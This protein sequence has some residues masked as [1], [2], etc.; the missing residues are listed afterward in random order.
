MQKF[1]KKGLKKKSEN[2]SEW[3]TDVILKAE[4]ADYAPVKGCMVIRPYGYS[5]W[6]GIRKFLDMYIKERGVKNA[7]FP[8]FIPE[9]Y[10]KMEK[11]HIE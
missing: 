4:L 10:L 2:L 9:K 8:V 11:E 5:L 1:E 3:Y 6:E 7:Y